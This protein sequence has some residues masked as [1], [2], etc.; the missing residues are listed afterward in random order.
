MK[1]RFKLLFS[2]VL[3][4]SY[5]LVKNNRK[6]YLGLRFFL[7]PMKIKS[8]VIW[9][10]LLIGTAAISIYL[11]AKG[12]TFKTEEALKTEIEKRDKEITVLENKIQQLSEEL[13]SRGI[14]SYPQAN[15]V[16]TKEDAVTNVVITLNGREEIEN[17]EIKRK[18]TIND[19][20]ETGNSTPKVRT[21]SIGTLNA[22]NPVNFEIE[23]FQKEILIEL[24]FNSGKEEWHQY[25]IARKTSDGET[26]SFW[27]ITNSEF[28]VID[29]HIDE[30]FPM[31]SE[32]I[33]VSGTNREVKYSE[34]KMNS[35]FRPTSLD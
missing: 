7:Q 22:H 27:V 2:G 11:G 17:L 19:P 34:I 6:H 32:G 1:R 20:D 24:T 18:L 33:I 10:A 26:R 29:K 21:V 23:N 31:E 28:E 8:D 9:A 35:V 30:G 16:A 13:I 3:L 5:R 14:F 25:I 12:G 15:I 4:N